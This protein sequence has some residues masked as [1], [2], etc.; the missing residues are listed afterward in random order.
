MNKYSR[1]Q[2]PLKQKVPFKWVFMENIPATPQK[3]LTSET[4]FFNFIVDLYSKIPEL[5]GTEIITTEEVIDRLDMFQAR[6][7]KIDGLG[8]WDSE[9]NSADTGT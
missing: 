5:Y 1:S 4:T 8:W 6:F 9:K 2:N 3:R 7:S